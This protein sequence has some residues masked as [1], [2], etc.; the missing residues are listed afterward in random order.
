MKLMW[1]GTCTAQH[2]KRNR[3]IL[4][5]PINSHIRIKLTIICVFYESD[6]G[7]QP[8]AKCV[9]V[10]NDERTTTKSIEIPLNRAIRP[11]IVDY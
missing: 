4:W 8:T 11:S 9:T 2:V 10:S 5:L 3:G 1:Q 6:N 7:T